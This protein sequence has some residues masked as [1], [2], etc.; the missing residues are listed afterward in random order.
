MR[1]RFFLYRYGLCS[2]LMAAW[3]GLGGKAASGPQ[4]SSSLPSPSA[5]VK[6]ETYVSLDRVPRGKEFE[7]AVVAEIARGFHMNSH[8]P[9]ETYLIPT[10]LTTQPPAGIQLLDTLYPHGELVKFPFLPDK[11]LDVYTGSV[12]LR[13]RLSVEAGAPLGG[14]TVPMTLRY[15][16]CNDTACLPPVKLPTSVRFE[17]VPAGAKTRALNPAILTAPA[18]T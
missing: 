12:T 8:T 3:L 6:P 5:V 9:S 15:Q 1:S 13:I 17:V 4:D 11:A 2:V 14:T 16:A 18:P 10:T 7:V